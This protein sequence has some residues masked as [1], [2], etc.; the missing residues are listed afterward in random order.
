MSEV[1]KAGSLGDGTLSLDAMILTWWSI[2]G[3]STL[4]TYST[5]LI[6]T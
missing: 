2:P 4:H 6:T 5:I 1:I 3:V